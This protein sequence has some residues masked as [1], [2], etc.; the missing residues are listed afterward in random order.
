MIKPGLYRWYPSTVVSKYWCWFHELG[1]PNLDILEDSNSGEWHIIQYHNSPLMPSTT[2]WN[3]VLGP[4]RNI[5]PSFSFCAKYIAELDITKK[6]FWAREE[7]KTKAVEDEGKKTDERSKV[8]AERATEAVMRNPDLVKRV[9]KNGL[10][11]IDLRYLGMR[12]PTHEFKP[13]FKGEKVD[14]CSPSEPAQ[15]D[16]HGE[17]SSGVHEKP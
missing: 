3:A 16:L 17:V 12:V 4:M 1:Y 11:E 14:V 10:K 8:F 15:Q 13:A 6:A 2:R 9:A 7:A 5:E